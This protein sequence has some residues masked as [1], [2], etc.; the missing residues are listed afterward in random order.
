MPNHSSGFILG[1][2]AKETHGC[3]IHCLTWSSDL[4]TSSETSHQKANLRN[5]SLDECS[6]SGNA[7]KNTMESASDTS[8]IRSST[9]QRSNLIR[10]FAT[11]G[12]NNV[13][14]YEVDINP[15]HASSN[16]T[17]RNKSNE[18]VTEDKGLRV[19]QFYCDDDQQEDFFACSFGGRGAGSYVD[20]PPSLISC[21]ATDE[22]VDDDK[23]LDESCRSLHGDDGTVVDKRDNNSKRRRIHSKPNNND[24]AFF[25]H[26][27]DI[28]RND[29]PEASPDM[30]SFGFKRTMYTTS[31]IIS[32]T[33]LL[34]I[35]FATTLS[36]FYASEVHAESSKSLIQFVA[37]C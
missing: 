32:L 6:S 15:V 35:V 10:Y 31:S 8:E 22:V 16:Q 13:T 30:Y 17:K 2:V 5:A 1:G 29:G 19:R 11:C 23:T 34:C 33:R 12:G 37:K 25:N 28:S 9:N 3:V 20:F 7:D 27:V 24:Y 18:S 36:S 26:V 14:V 21:L 4:Y